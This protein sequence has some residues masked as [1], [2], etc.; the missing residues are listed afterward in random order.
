MMK[1]KLNKKIAGATAMLMLSATMLGTSTF[2]WFTMNREVE[3]K[4]MQVKAHAEEGLLI[5]EVPDAQSD[6]WDELALAGQGTSADDFIQLRPA[7]TTPGFATWWHANSLKFDNRAGYGSGTVDSDKTA[8]IGNT[9]NYYEDI[10]SISTS[11][12][13]AV[14]GTNAKRTV[15]YKD[16]TYGGGA[17]G[18]YQNG[19]GFYVEY[20]YYIK[21]SSSTDLSIA[22]GNF[23]TTVTATKKNTD[24]SGTSDNLDSALRV[25]VKITDGNN[26]AYSKIFA[27][28]TGADSTY[29]VTNNATGSTYTTVNAATTP[30]AINDGALVVPA[31]TKNGIKVQVYIWFE[32]EDRNCMSKNLTAVLDSYQIDI[33]FKDTTN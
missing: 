13:D 22:S 19:E 24:T 31:V 20:D 25:G 18:A 16:A 9:N 4:G 12:T 28:I 1:M 7:S 32:G 11:V 10:T 15:Y 6:Y 23:E 14:A 8:K 3:V 30:A 26:T 21:S 17:S 2:A 29:H 5:N 27:P 33:K